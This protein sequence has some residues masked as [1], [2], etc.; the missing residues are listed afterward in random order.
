MKKLTIVIMSIL[1]TSYSLAVE[2]TGKFEI[3]NRGTAPI[4]SINLDV[5]GYTVTPLESTSSMDDSH[6]SAKSGFFKTPLL[7]SL[8]RSFDQSAFY[9]DSFI[10]SYSST[11]VKGYGPVK[12]ENGEGGLQTSRLFDV[13]DLG[14]EP[15]FITGPIESGRNSVPESSTMLLLGLGLIGLSAYGGRKKFKR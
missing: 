14:S 15:L 5:T 1:L 10:G 2:H 11:P 7:S 12:F 9:F 4:N 13:F 8:P 6:Q 3:D